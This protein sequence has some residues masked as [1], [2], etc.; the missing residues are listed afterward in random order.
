MNE[1]MKYV[2]TVEEREFFYLKEAL[3]SAL[4]ISIPLVR[5]I[6]KRTGVLSLF[7]LSPF[8]SSYIYSSCINQFRIK[9]SY[10]TTQSIVNMHKP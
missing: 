10:I 9:C 7:Y 6:S 1:C 5:P 2:R 8:K 3:Q 4:S